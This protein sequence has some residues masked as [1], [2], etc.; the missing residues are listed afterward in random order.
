MIRVHVVVV[1]G[2]ASQSCRSFQSVLEIK[3][4]G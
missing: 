2:I 3:L 4:L 1:Y